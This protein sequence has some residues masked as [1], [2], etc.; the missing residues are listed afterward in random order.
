MEKL[1]IGQQVYYNI[2]FLTLVSKLVGLWAGISLV[3]VRIGPVVL[4]LFL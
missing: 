3:W 1:S 4:T 2:G